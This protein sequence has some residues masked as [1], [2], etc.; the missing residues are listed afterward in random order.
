[1]SQGVML[2]WVIY[3]WEIEQKDKADEKGKLLSELSM[4]VKPK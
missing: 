1:M 3:K 4:V 2:A